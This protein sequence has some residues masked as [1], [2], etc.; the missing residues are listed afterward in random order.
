MRTL[1]GLNPDGKITAWPG[2]DIRQSSWLWPKGTAPAPMVFRIPT[3]LCQ[4]VFHPGPGS[5][6]FCT[7]RAVSYYCTTSPTYFAVLTFKFCVDLTEF[8]FVKQ[9]QPIWA[10][11]A[12]AFYIIE[13]WWIEN[14]YSILWNRQD[15]ENMFDKLLGQKKGLYYD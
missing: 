12:F 11:I 1:A 5:L 4:L 3:W 6:L 7:H 9:L 14:K 8:P 13:Q 2:A 10:I 15:L